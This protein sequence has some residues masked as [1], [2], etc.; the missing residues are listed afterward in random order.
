[1]CGLPEE[2]SRRPELGEPSAVHDRDAIGERCD[3]GQVV[4]HVDRSD[5]V[6]CA[7]V[8]DRLEH[9][10]LGGH[11]EPRRGFVQHDHTGP[12]GEGHGQRDPLL[13]AARQLVRIAVQEHVVA[14]EQHLAERLDDARAPLLVGRAETVGRQRLV[15]LRLDLQRRVQRGRGVLGDVGDEL[16]SELLA[17]ERGEQEDVSTLD[18]DLASGDSCAATRVTEHREA[19]RRLPG[20]RLADEAEDLA[21]GDVERDAVHDVLV[22]AVLDLDP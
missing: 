3:H 11:V 19:D 6:R 22:R 12:V 7:E 13:L 5:A 21:R 15:E 2:R 9:V 20:S 18:A 10:G 14:R 17:L 8:A 1:M 16:A 4:T